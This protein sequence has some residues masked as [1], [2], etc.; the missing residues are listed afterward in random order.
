MKNNNKRVL[1]TGCSGF[2][3]TYITNILRKNG[4]NVVG[5]GLRP[6][7]DKDYIQADI[8]DIASLE[9]EILS[10]IPHPDYVIHLAA[11]SFVGH[12]NISDFYNTNIVGTRNLLEVLTKLKPTIK[13]VL[14]SSSANIY[15]NNTEGQLNEN[16][17]FNPKND[18][19]VSKLG[20]EFI[21]KIYSEK[22]PIVIL[23][24]FNY[25]GVGQNINFVIPKIISHF[26]KKLPS[27]ELGNMDIKREFN[28]VR[29]VADVYVKILEEVEPFNIINVCTG[30]SFTLQ[31]VLCTCQEI[32]NHKVNV[33]INP[34]FVRENEV[35]VL[36]GDPKK[37][38]SLIT[39]YEH[40]SL[41]QTME[42]M[43]EEE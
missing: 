12:E 21:S 34:M 32:T 28:D 5:L 43:L 13:K 1:I 33:K 14:I 37:L 11:K 29:F 27:I 23:R 20:M 42:W 31:E 15:G 16:T 18:Y 36:S 26:K 2:T 6:S 19:A 41:K 39:G 25:T 7:N 4:Y 30:S 38:N 3:G 17:Q 22:L 10:S 24:P 40:Y 35:K 9:K 8:Q